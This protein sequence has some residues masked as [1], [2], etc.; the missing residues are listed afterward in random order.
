MTRLC[1]FCG[2]SPGARSEYAA[3]ARALAAELVR[4]GIGLVYGGGNVGLM[5]ILADGV[6]AG[7]GE[8]IGVIPEALVA[9]E[10]AHHGLTTLHVVASMHERKA[11][12][13]E[14]SSGFIALPGGLGTFEEFFEAATWTQLGVHAKPCALLNIA[15]YYDPLIEA[16]EHARDERFVPAAHLEMVLADTDPGRLL[17]RLA[18]WRAPSVPKWLD[19]GQV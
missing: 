5:G 4:R 7:G 13:S 9:R 2:S 17:D 19:R 14:L 1:V 8:A 18:A 6:L 10:I 11:L 3:G 15:G 12:M 16:L